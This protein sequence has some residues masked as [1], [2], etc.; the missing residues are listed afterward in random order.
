MSVTLN[1]E[2]KTHQKVDERGIPLKELDRKG[3][4]SH[5]R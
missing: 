3:K 5:S 2:K 4:A 1:L